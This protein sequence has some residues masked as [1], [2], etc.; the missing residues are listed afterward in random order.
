MS[1][2]YFT[3][4][5]ER[6][7]KCTTTRDNRYVMDYKTKKFF[8]RK[9]QKRDRMQAKLAIAAA[10]LADKLEQADEKFATEVYAPSLFPSS[11]WKAQGLSVSV[12]EGY[13]RDGHAVVTLDLETDITDYDV[14]G[15]DYS[16]IEELWWATQDTSQLYR[17]PLND[18]YGL[19]RYCHEAFMDK[20]EGAID[21]LWTAKEY[22]E[23][24]YRQC[25]T[26]ELPA[27]EPADEEWSFFDPL[28]IETLDEVLLNTKPQVGSSKR[29]R[30]ATIRKL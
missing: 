27:D 15:T 9:L 4:P 5:R 21:E 8:A 14:F 13:D 18:V 2:T 11:K 30:R 3:E 26:Y 22:S 19:P 7:L 10:V 6:V 16:A 17:P 1:K 28:S 25:D 29:G 24:F 20:V 23:E 12:Y